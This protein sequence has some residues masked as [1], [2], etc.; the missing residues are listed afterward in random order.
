MSKVLIKST[1]PA[2]LNGMSRDEFLDILRKALDGRAESAYI[3]GS[4]WTDAFSSES[5]IDLIIIKNTTLRFMDRAQEF[6]DLYEIYCPMDILV[7][8]PDEFETLIHEPRGFWKSVV[9]SM[10]Q[11]V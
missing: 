6:N 5:D 10:R 4:F 7:Y 9:E 3:F 2:L 11:I 1:S 8:R